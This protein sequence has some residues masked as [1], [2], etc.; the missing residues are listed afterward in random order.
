MHKIL[1][2]AMR[3]HHQIN[4]RD[5]KFSTNLKEASWGFQ[6]TVRSL[7]GH[8]SHGGTRVIERNCDNR[9][10][11]ETMRTWI[12]VVVFPSILTE[13]VSWPRTDRWG[14]VSSLVTIFIIPS[15]LF[16]PLSTGTPSTCIHYVE[17][18]HSSNLGSLD[19]PQ[20]CWWARQKRSYPMGLRGQREKSD[21]STHLGQPALSR[22]FAW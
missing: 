22:F 3:S 19:P 8:A 10:L 9:V 5:E 13:Q 6:E 20:A 16:Y 17:V 21:R 4:R 12:N 7:K 15:V 1:R 14:W 11:E 2:Q 18:K